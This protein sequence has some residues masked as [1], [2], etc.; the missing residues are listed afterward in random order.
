MLTVRVLVVASAC[1]VTGLSAQA[2]APAPT[3]DGVLRLAGEYV[4][5]YAGRLSA[6]VAEER[7]TQRDTPGAR[8]IGGTR[9]LVSDFL[10]VRV[11]GTQEW[12][13]FRD[14]FEVNAWKVR[15]RQERL[16]NLFVQSPGDA[17]ERA[18]RISDESARYNI[19]PIHRTINLPT[20][21]LLFIAPSS[22]PRFTFKKAGEETVD[23]VRYWVVEGKEHQ[24]PT[25][26]RSS[27]GKYW[28]LTTRYW[29][30]PA[31]GRIARTD[32]RVSEGLRSAVTVD[33]K[34]DGRLGLW[35]PAAMKESYD[36]GSVM[37]RCEATYSNYRAF[38]VNTSEVFR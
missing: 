16:L 15:D 3:L 5:D 38:Q 10:L 19:G 28:F 33:Y 22:Q 37:I 20:T 21:A 32:M 2:P 6:V 12:I 27:L 31:S 4:A 7:Y 35:V 18:R 36:Q 13:G 26:I 9:N 8:S 30:D 23:G 14:V 25:F 1:L 24:T 34:P 11:P 17:I 29:I